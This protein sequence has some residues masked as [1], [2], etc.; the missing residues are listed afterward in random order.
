MGSVGN[1]EGRWYMREE[2]KEGGI[3]REKERG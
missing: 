2:R 1:V 3:G